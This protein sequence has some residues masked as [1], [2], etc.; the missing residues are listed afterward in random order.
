RRLVPAPRAATRRVRDRVHLVVVREDV[1]QRRVLHDEG[2]LLVDEVARDRAVVLLAE[3]FEVAADDGGRNSEIQ[4]VDG[5]SLTAQ[6]AGR[7]RYVAGAVRA[8]GERK[9]LDAGAVSG[10]IARADGTV[11]NCRSRGRRSARRGGAVTVR[12]AARDCQNRHD[13]AGRRLDPSIW[14]TGHGA[15]KTC[16]RNV[17]RFR[18]VV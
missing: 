2:H 6:L 13:S 1:H 8:V 12:L 17:G 7:Y 18:C 4:E 3:R 11:N 9:A 5:E 16:N 14:S 10:G 15:W